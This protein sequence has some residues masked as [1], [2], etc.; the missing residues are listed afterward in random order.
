MAKILTSLCF[1]LTVPLVFGGDYAL[2]QSLTGY[3][4]QVA[5]SESYQLVTAWGSPPAEVLQGKPVLHSQTHAYLVLIGEY[6]S[7]ESAE[8]V[9]EGVEVVAGWNK[10]GW[11]GFFYAKFYPWVYHKNLGWIYVSEKENGGT[12]FHFERFGW[13]W[14][15][16]D[17]FPS[18]YLQNRG[19]WTYLDVSGSETTLY[20]Y[21]NKTWFQANRPC[22]I[23]GSLI[24]ADG[25]TVTGY[26]E[27]YRWETATLTASPA[28]GYNFSGWGGDFRGTSTKAVLEVLGDATIDAAFVPVITPNS[29]PGKIVSESFDLIKSMKNLTPGQQKRSMA[30][31]LIRGKSDTSGISILPQVKSEGSGK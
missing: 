29:D 7:G 30:E 4:V 11:F 22:V 2:E 5:S 20:D 18:L 15:N 9:S 24:P 3:E 8:M 1:F 21:R 14:T 10:V 25:G 31:L 16:K 12:W 19:E 17:T 13:I 6:L 26:G 28:E 23:Q 27:Y